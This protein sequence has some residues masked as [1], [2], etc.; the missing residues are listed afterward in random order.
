MI[1][2]QALVQSAILPPEAGIVQLPGQLRDLI[3]FL[4]GDG[5][6]L[7]G[8]VCLPAGEEAHNILIFC[9]LRGLLFRRRRGFPGRVCLRGGGRLLRGIC[10]A[11]RRCLRNDILGGI[12]I[13]H[14]HTY[15]LR[16]DQLFQKRD[17]PVFHAIGWIKNGGKQNDSR[18]C[19]GRKGQGLFCGSLRFHAID[20]DQE[21]REEKTEDRSF[22]GGQCQRDRKEN[23]QRNIQTKCPRCRLLIEDRVCHK[24][25]TQ[26]DQGIRQRH[27][28]IDAQLRYAIL[29]GWQIKPYAV[30]DRHGG[31][32]NGIIAADS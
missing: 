27:G 14:T 1:S 3:I 2:F 6:V 5:S 28:G 25:H 30:V 4:L 26:R 8:L 21:R 20:R 23:I 16:G 10:L 31:K 9:I 15:G 17:P 22:T 29:S 24:D 13:L 12:Q 19:P 11:R 32:G 7:Q 18:Q